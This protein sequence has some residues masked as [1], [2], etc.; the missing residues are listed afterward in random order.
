[1]ATEGKIFDTGNGKNN[2]EFGCF[3]GAEQN[4]RTQERSLSVNRYNEFLEDY[5]AIQV[6]IKQEYDDSSD[7]VNTMTEDSLPTA[8]VSQ[9][10]QHSPTYN[11]SYHSSLDNSITDN[12]SME[13]PPYKLMKLEEI[14]DTHG[15]QVLYKDSHMPIS[16]KLEPPSPERRQD[17]LSQV[18]FPNEFEMRDKDVNLSSPSQIK[19]NFHIKLEPQDG[20]G[21]FSSPDL[22]PDSP[23]SSSSGSYLPGVPSPIQSQVLKD[24]DSNSFKNATVKADD[25]QK[26][27]Q[28]I[29]LSQI[30]S[31]FSNINRS[32]DRPKS[33]GQMFALKKRIKQAQLNGDSSLS[34]NSKRL[35]KILPAPGKPVQT[36]PVDLSVNKKTY[37]AMISGTP[38]LHELGGTSDLDEPPTV[39][40]ET[41][42]KIGS[43]ALLSLQRIKAASDKFK[44][45]DTCNNNTVPSPQPITMPYTLSPVPNCDPFIDREKKRRVHRCDFDGCNKVYTKSSHLKAHRRTHTGEKPYV[46]NWEGPSVATHEEAL[47]SRQ[48]LI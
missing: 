28:L 17:Y 48:W 23:M 19:N 27:L 46:C 3:D 21:S 12:S 16:V 30:R 2:T 42:N 4:L 43:A 34:E 8:A 15:Q 13:E 40:L 9:K 5:E 35:V 39:T 38:P 31:A 18:N 41:V 47:R 6:T 45:L 36:E 1:M 33:V 29:K 25:Q 20:E 22:S 7:Q 14:M 10:R 32:N 44:S 11:N 37:D 26:Q 24:E